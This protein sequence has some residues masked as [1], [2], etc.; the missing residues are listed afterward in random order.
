MTALPDFSL[1][2]P[3]AHD[4]IEATRA[5]AELE[6]RALFAA[7][8]PDALD[9]IEQARRSAARE[10]LEALPDAET[11]AAECEAWFRLV[12]ALTEETHVERPGCPNGHHVSELAW[13]PDRRR[14]KGGYSYCRACRRE[15]RRE[16]GW[17]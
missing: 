13:R 8:R 2:E 16:R 1:V 7:L 6:L 3:E 10:L 12:G 15:E 4:G 11:P 9:G 14:K 5:D 17:S